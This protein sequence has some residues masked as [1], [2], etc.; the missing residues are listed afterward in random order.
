MAEEQR[1]QRERQ[2]R[3]A[4]EREAK[5]HENWHG[6]RELCGKLGDDGMR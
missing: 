5:A 4:A 2:E 3:E 6:P 1:A